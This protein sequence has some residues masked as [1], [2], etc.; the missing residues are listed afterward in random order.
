MSEE[1]NFYFH[2]GKAISRRWADNYRMFFS[3]GLVALVGAVVSTTSE[4][5]AVPRILGSIAII[6]GMVGIFL[7]HRSRGIII[8]DELD[9]DA[10]KVGLLSVEDLG[11]RHVHLTKEEHG[12][13]LAAIEKEDAIINRTNSH[14]GGDEVALEIGYERALG[15][16]KDE[17]KRRVAIRSETFSRNK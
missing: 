14:E 9:I 12:D 7:G 16:A 10:A 15:A 1:S 5:R 8:K 2:E 3:S 11:K 6:C 4:R 13:L 17:W